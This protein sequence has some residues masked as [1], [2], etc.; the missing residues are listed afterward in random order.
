V[1]RAY[2]V[3]GVVMVLAGGCRSV[4]GIDSL[5]VI[6]AGTTEEAGVAGGDASGEA[7]VPGDAEGK[8][9]DGGG[10]VADGSAPGVDAA[11]E[12]PDCAPSGANC[13]MCCRGDPAL[14]EH[15]LEQYAIEAGCFCG[16]TSMCPECTSTTFCNGT[17]QPPPMTG[18]CGPCLGTALDADG[19][20]CA[21]ARRECGRDPSCAP[22]LDCLATCPSP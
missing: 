8:G 5:E 3:V 22:V 9:T 14:G 1:R 10:N 11:P 15:S 4:L 12:L 19:G 7:A 20:P 2:L 17:G 21:A 13:N 6:E 18:T 16:A